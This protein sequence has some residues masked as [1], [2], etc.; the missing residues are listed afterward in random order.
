M[1]SVSSASEIP[2]TIVCRK[3]TWELNW[4]F[5]FSL[6]TKD[7]DFKRSGRGA[8]F[9]EHLTQALYKLLCYC[10]K[11]ISS[12]HTCTEFNMYLLNACYRIATRHHEGH[13]ETEDL[14]PVPKVPPVSV[15]Q[16]HRPVSNCWNVTET[17]KRADSRE[18]IFLHNG[19]PV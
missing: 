14:I 3:I 7:S 4:N 19:C 5:R 12:G 17:I 15:K 11:K 1:G 18:L 6:P 8:H 16:L 9:N 2:K 10:K 13:K